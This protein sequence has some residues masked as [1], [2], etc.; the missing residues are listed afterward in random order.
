MNK[1][2]ANAQAE[3]LRT[4]ADQWGRDEASGSREVAFLLAR[5]AKM[6]RDGEA[7]EVPGV[8]SAATLPAAQV[9]SELTS[10]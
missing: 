5:A 10:D 3:T 9:Q 6:M 2:I 4:W 8:A 1:A 7:D